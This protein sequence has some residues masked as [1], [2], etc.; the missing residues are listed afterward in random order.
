MDNSSVYP[1]RVF[2]D[3]DLDSLSINNY[4][5]FENISVF[6]NKFNQLPSAYDADYINFTLFN[7]K[8]KYNNLCVFEGYLV[9]NYNFSS[10]KK[11]YGS[12]A[13]HFEVYLDKKI[14]LNKDI[15]IKLINNL[16]K[17]IFVD[18]N[19]DCTELKYFNPEISVYLNSLS[20]NNLNIEII[21]KKS[22]ITVLKIEN[23]GNCPVDITKFFY[24]TDKIYKI[25]P[26]SNVNAT[27]FVIYPK[28][29]EIFNF[30]NFENTICLNSL[31]FRKCA[32]PLI[33]LKE[34]NFSTD[35]FLVGEEYGGSVQLEIFVSDAL[36][37]PLKLEAMDPSTI[38][39]NPDII[40]P[41]GYN[42]VG[43][44]YKYTCPVGVTYLNI[45][46]EAVDT[47]TGERYYIDTIKIIISNLAV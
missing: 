47:I 20:L 14:T 10:Q 31:G 16:I 4:L 2:Y 46:L 1:M 7:K 5:N 23:L 8:K 42:S 34:N 22:N 15:Y 37:N 9:Q 3:C 45:D 29:Y 33:F 12:P 17:E 13:I 25:I 40:Y 19:E 21:E 30:S 43:L 11:I 18:F 32:Q 24:E 44:T 26:N 27:S 41:G 36:K 39:F 6:D 28:R 35:C 38:S